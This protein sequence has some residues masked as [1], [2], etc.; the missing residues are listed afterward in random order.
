[1]LKNWKSIEVVPRAAVPLV[2]WKVPALTKIGV[3]PE[4][5][6]ILPS[7]VLMKAAPSKLLM[8]A[9]FDPVMLPALQTVVA[10]L[11]SR[12]PLRVVLPWIAIPPLATISLLVMLPPPKVNAPVTVIGLVPPRIPAETF[13]VA[14]VPALSKTSTLPELVRS[15]VVPATLQPG[16][17]VAVPA[18]RLR[19]VPTSKVPLAVR[20]APPE[21]LRVPAPVTK[22][23]A[24]RTWAPPPKLR[25]APEALLKD[26]E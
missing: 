6:A 26:P 22:E 24:L 17:S 15:S 13:T 21:R 7:K 3:R 16:A 11:T 1:M 20:V 9:P 12:T 4:P 18:A 23:P 10:G 5:V 25:E 19:V 14:T 2:F 8:A